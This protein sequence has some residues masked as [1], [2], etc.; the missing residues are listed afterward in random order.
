MS[1]M[2]LA[3]LPLSADQGWPELARLRPGLLKVFCLLVLPLSLLPP[4]MLYF[5]GTHYPEAFLP[6]ARQKD[7]ATVA[8]VFFLAEMGTLLLM[9]WLIKQVA[10]TYELTIDYHDSYLLAA[11]AP[12]PMWLSSLGLLVPSLTLNVIVSISGLALSCAILYHG[13]QALGRRR[14]E[15]VAAEVV[16]IVIGAGLIVWALLLVLAFV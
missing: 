12:V 3:K 7:W 1:L 5:A 15:V 2:S 6:P 16:Q 14:E 9:G 13:L 10:E 8:A 4:A 11:V